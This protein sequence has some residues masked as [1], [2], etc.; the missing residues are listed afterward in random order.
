MHEPTP[1]LDTPPIPAAGDLPADDP[2]NWGLDLWNGSAWFSG[3]FVQRLQ[4]TGP[5]RERLDDLR[6]HLPRGA[7]ESLLAGIRNHL[8]RHV[9]LDLTVRV[10][11]PDGRLEWWHVQGVAEHNTAGQPMYLSGR[12]RDVGA[13]HGAGYQAADL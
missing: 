10:T 13:P 7:W 11:L 4:W 8:E 3:W 2:W 9:P 6:P 5:E 1:P 12:V